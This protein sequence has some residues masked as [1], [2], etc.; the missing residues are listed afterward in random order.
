MRAGVPAEELAG[1]PLSFVNRSARLGA[2]RAH[3]EGGVPTGVIT[4]PRRDEYSLGHLFYFFEYACAISGYIGG[5]NPFD[6]PGEE[7]YKTYMREL[8]RQEK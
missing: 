1:K 3:I 5:I 8:L 7:R 6:Q 4:L 2:I